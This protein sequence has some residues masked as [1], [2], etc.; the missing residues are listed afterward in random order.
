MRALATI[1]IAAMACNYKHVTLP[2]ADPAAKTCADSCAASFDLSGNPD[3]YRGCIAACPGAQWTEGKCGGADRPPIA[4]CVPDV[5][6][7]A[8]GVLAFGVGV[9]GLLIG[10]LFFS[11]LDDVGDTV[12]H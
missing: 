10:G 12:N 6:L 9:I 8:I 1:A 2:L 5:E 3:W 7:K 4:I 11:A